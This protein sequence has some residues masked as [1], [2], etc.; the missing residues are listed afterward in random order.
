MHWPSI[1]LYMSSSF[2]IVI[3]NKIVLTAFSFTSVPFIMLAQSI[4][5]AIVTFIRD[6]NAIQKPKLDIVLV[7]MFSASNI[8]FGLSSA[9]ALNIAMFTALRRISIFMT[10]VAQYYFFQ[11]PIHKA[12][13]SSVV[14][15]ILGS[16]VA[17]ANDL[18]FSMEGYTYVTVNNILTV[19]AQIQTKKTLSKK[20]TKTSILFWTS[21]LTAC[22]SAMSLTHWDPASF[23][24]WHEPAFQFAFACSVVL[25][26]AINYS[27]AW[28]IEQNDALTLAV[29]GSTKSAIMGLMVTAGL[30][31]RT[32]IF[33]W[34]N[35]SGLQISTLGSFMYVWF[36]NNRAAGTPQTAC[37]E[38][39]EHNKATRGTDLKPDTV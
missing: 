2:M 28:T 23:K 34:W 4:F 3:F 7:C 30:F 9:A 8:F 5:T 18:A 33:S 24:A 27:Y 37:Y 26:F 25:G 21:V 22:I 13:F 12:V 16:L 17:A 6:C 19:A 38:R 36:R 29:A 11:E 14:I 32:Y 10:M 15:M 35:F 20:W 31:D 39:S 1:L